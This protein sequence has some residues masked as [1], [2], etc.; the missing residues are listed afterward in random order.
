MLPSLSDIRE[1][2]AQS[3]AGGVRR[4]KPG[5]RCST[6]F[7]SRWQPPAL[8]FILGPLATN[9]LRVGNALRP[10]LDGLHAGSSAR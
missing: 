10:P 9:P 2:L 3:E 1:A 7:P 8:A 4:D 6:T 5:E